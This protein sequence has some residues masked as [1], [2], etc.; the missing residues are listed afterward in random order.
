MLT[1]FSALKLII[2]SKILL[3]FQDVSLTKIDTDNEENRAAIIIIARVLVR[4]IRQ[5]V[6]RK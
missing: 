3:L 1:I 5:K 2:K 6:M 4:K